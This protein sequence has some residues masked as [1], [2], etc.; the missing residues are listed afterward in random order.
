MLVKSKFHITNTVL[1]FKSLLTLDTLISNTSA[2]SGGGDD[3]VGSVSKQTLL[4]ALLVL[5]WYSVGA[6]LSAGSVAP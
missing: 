6:E 1:L 2:S 4:D 3:L 5:P